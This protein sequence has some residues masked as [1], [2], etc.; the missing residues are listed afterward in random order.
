MDVSWPCHNWL[1]TMMATPIIPPKCAP[2][3]VLKWL[4]PQIHATNT[5]FVSVSRDTM[6]QAGKAYRPSP[7]ELAGKLAEARALIKARMWRPASRPKLK[8]DFD[9]LE[10]KFNVETTTNE[11]QTALLLTAANECTSDDYDGS[12]PPQK[13]YEETIIGQELFAFSYKS[14]SLGAQM[15]FKFAIKGVDKGRRVYPC[16]IHESTR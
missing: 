5:L 11:D 8:V 13:S 9:K 1:D 7:K 16:S 2:C 14:A 12:Y 10:A 15:Y 3:Q 6:S 4:Q